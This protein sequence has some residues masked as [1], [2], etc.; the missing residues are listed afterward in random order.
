MDLD[1]LRYAGPRPV[2]GDTDL[3]RRYRFMLGGTE[4]DALLPEAA[5]TVWRQAHPGADPSGPLQTLGVVEVQDALAAAQNRDLPA[6]FDHRNGD[7]LAARAH[8]TCAP[9]GTPC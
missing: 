9:R 4:I 6:A 2:H 5:A 7:R 8:T 3:H 1:D